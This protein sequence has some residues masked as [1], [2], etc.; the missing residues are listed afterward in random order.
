MV[1]FLSSVGSGEL[2][3]AGS[4]FL[5]GAC[6]V[7]LRQGM[8]T[9]TPLAAVLIIHG[10]VSAG[11]LGYSLYDGS[12]ANSTLPPLLWF[13]ALGIM[14]Q[15]VGTFTHFIGIERMGVS[16]ATLVQASTPIWGVILAVSILG[17]RPSI[18]VVMGTV[19]IV[20]GVT[21]FAF[22]E[23]GRQRERFAVWFRGELIFPLIS[24]VAYAMLPV[25]SK[26][27]FAYQ[28]T[29]ILGL[30]VAFASGSLV[31]LMVRPLLPG[32]GRIRVKPAG[33]RWFALAGLFN[34]FA[35]SLYWNALMIGQISSVLPLSRLYPLWV[36]IFSAVFLGGLERIT[37]RVVLAALLVVAGGVLITVS[38]G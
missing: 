11:A 15:G 26:F 36:V 19:F 20:T 24:S 27:A 13:A 4:T 35:A 7:S 6:L 10:L 31:L 12:M 23:G 33:A 2:M 29:P 16:R 30:G 28:R 9:G 14:G 21:L 22:R 3:A 1:N 5:Y 38:A 25:F 18:W 34:L 32:G 37:L 8:R 17:E